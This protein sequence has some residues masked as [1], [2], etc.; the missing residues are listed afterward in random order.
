MVAQRNGVDVDAAFD[1]L[2]AHAR[3]HQVRLA[4]LARAVVEG[5]VDIPVSEG[6]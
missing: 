6:T 1:R 4:D 5:S 3:H 2:R